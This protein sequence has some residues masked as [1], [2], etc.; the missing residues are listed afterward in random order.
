MG[1]NDWKILLIK[2]QKL[3]GICFLFDLKLNPFELG[4]EFDA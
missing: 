2:G 1:A 3:V 4:T